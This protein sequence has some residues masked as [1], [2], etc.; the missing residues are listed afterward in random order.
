M[1]RAYP[2]KVCFDCRQTFKYDMFDYCGYCGKRLT[3]AVL[4]EV[5]AGATT[6]TSEST[7]SQVDSQVS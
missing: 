3:D 2:V 1:L 5:P 4:T 6:D 7:R